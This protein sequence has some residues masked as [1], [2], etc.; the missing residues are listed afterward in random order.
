MLLGRVRATIPGKFETVFLGTALS[1]FPTGI[2]SNKEIERFRVS[3]KRRAGPAVKRSRYGASTKLRS[4]TQGTRP[5]KIGQEGRK[6]GSQGCG[7]RA[8]E[9][10][11]RD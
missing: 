8:F 2:A 9:A 4:G 10:G 1:A 3:M 7:A 11:R 5:S 6:A